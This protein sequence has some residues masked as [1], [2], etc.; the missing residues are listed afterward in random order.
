[1]AAVHFV[2]L[3]GNRATLASVELLIGIMSLS[4]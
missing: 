4:L 3:E 2:R 1:M